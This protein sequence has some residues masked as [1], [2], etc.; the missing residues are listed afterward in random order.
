MLALLLVAAA[1][2]APAHPDLSGCWT[3]VPDPTPRTRGDLGSGWGSPLTVTQ[4]ADRL[5]L[6]YAF[7]TPGEL[8]S[9]LRFTYAFDGTETST[10]VWMGHGPQEL[11]AHAHW[12]GDRLVIVTAYPLVDP[13]TG[14]AMTVDVTR[15]LA[16]ASPTS[17][18][19]E[20]TTAA[21]LGGRP[22]STRVAYDRCP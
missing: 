10:V 18:T 22:T 11:R 8:Q 1:S 4:D 3:L 9:P 6:Q 5:G 15:T 17:L 12:E 14:A 7:F 19:V 20:T 21:V 2:A 16:L 13:A